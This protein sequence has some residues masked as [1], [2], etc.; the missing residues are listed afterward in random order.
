MIEVFDGLALWGQVAPRLGKGQRRAAVAYLGAGALTYL[1][2]KKHDV[3][4]F[5]GHR[6]SVAQ[7]HVDI[8]EVRAMLRSG[9]KLYSRPGLHSKMMVVEAKH[10]VA[11]V[12]SANASKTSATKKSETVVLF[13]DPVAVQSVRDAIGGLTVGLAPIGTP[14]AD[15]MAKLV[16]KLRG[17]ES[18][19]ERV[20]NVDL[21]LANKSKPMWVFD[22]EWSSEQWSAQVNQAIARAEAARGVIVWAFPLRSSYAS[23][24]DKVSEGDSVVFIPFQ[25]NASAPRR[26]ARVEEP[27]VVIDKIARPS[28]KGGDLL[29][30]WRHNASVVQW[31]QFQAAFDQARLDVSLDNLP[32]KARRVVFQLFASA[33]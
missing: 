31:H 24:Y 8:K 5:D 22:Y 2:L 33:S 4:V 10:P 11:V 6:S 32:P 17:T 3:L 20:V 28:G 14:W 18:K 19:F 26:N 21:P 1:G 9:V 16:P 12:G 15:N 29:V 13:D 27:G 25:S 23:F 30:A 7:G